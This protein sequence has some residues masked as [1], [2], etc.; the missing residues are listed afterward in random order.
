MLELDIGFVSLVFDLQKD[1]LSWFF[2]GCVNIERKAKP[3]YSSTQSQVRPNETAITDNA[4]NRNMAGQL[5]CD[6]GE[7]IL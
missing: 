6:S 3:P 1:W 5:T 4:G 2:P 7:D